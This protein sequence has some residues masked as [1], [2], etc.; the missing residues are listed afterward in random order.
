ME[1]RIARLGELGVRSSSAL[2]RTLDA[3]RNALL[4]APEGTQLLLLTAT[5]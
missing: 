1:A 2:P 4:E 5:D 3:R